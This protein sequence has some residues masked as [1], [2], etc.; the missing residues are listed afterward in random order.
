MGTFEYIGLFKKIV[1]SWVFSDPI[2]LKTFIY[3]LCTA[4]TDERAIEW[5]G[6][7]IIVKAGDVITGRKHLMDTL[8][9]TEREARRSL[10]LLIDNKMIGMAASSTYNVITILKFEEYQ[11]L[12]KKRVGNNLADNVQLDKPDTTVSFDKFWEA[13]PK[14]KRR[15]KMMAKKSWARINPNKELAGKIMK[16]LEAH[17][18]DE[19]WTKDGGMFIP[20]PVTWLNQRRWED[21]LDECVKMTHVNANELK[22]EL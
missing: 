12:V 22:G 17:K 10:E 5:H 15:S 18:L 1:D 20:M 21:E 11:G 4:S 6:K 19:Q 9:Y 16:G 8:S 13:W 14:H 3:F 7:T 2:V